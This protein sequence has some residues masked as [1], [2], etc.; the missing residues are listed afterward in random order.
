MQ[1]IVISLLEQRFGSVPR[2]IAEEIRTIQGP[3]LLA[4]LNLAAA[5][6][7]TIEAFVTTLRSLRH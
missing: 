1:Q 4:E 7:E 2:L 3:K 6:A 5:E